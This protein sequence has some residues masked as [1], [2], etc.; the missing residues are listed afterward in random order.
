MKI[1]RTTG[2]SARRTAKIIAALEQRGSAALDAVLPAVK[3]IVAD[4]RR[5]GDR[6][7]MRYARRFDGLAGPDSLR[8]GCDE[9]AAA[10]DS[11]DPLLRS[12]L[13]VAAEQIRKFATRQMPQS[14]SDSPVSG[15]TTGQLVRPLG[16]VGCY[17]PSG[18][19]PLPSTLLMTA[20]PAKVAGV[21]R[22]AVAVTDRG[23][24]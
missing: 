18:R 13:T 2:S 15:L 22:I 6:A 3:R 14:W 9:M 10:W 7:M 23:E 11:A 16:S 24:E 8:V 17:V 5:E 4:V 20:I 21:Q 12:A 1:I 19:H